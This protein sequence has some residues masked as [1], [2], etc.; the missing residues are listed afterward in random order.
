MIRFTNKALR[1][2]TVFTLYNDSVTCYTEKKRSFT[3]LRKT[4]IGTTRNRFILRCYTLRMSAKVRPAVADKPCLLSC[5]LT[6]PDSVW[7]YIRNPNGRWKTRCFTLKK[8]LT[9]R[10][11]AG[12][13]NQW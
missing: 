12:Q 7:H 4:A 2:V 1:I 8:R 11:V 13:D 9:E 6:R 10:E 3:V 5:H